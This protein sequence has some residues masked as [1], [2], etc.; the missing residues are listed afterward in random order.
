VVDGD[1]D[2]MESKWPRFAAARL[3]GGYVISLQIPGSK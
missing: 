2:T 3:A 1:A